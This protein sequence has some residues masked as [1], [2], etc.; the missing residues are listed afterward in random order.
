MRLILRVLESP[1]QNPCLPGDICRDEDGNWFVSQAH[2]KFEN[3]QDEPKT[4]SEPDDW[5]YT[6]DDSVPY[7]WVDVTDGTN[8]GLTEMDG[9]LNISLPFDFPFYWNHYSNLYIVTPGYLT[10]YEQPVVGQSEIPN[11]NLPNGIIAPFWAP[12]MP[13]M[14]TGWIRYMTGGTEPNRYLVV[15][16]YE[17]QDSHGNRFTFEVILY[18]NGNILFQYQQIGE[19]YWCASTGIES[20]TAYYG[21]AYP[22]WCDNYPAEG[23]AV[24]FTRPGPVARF[25]VDELYL[26]KFAQPGSDVYYYF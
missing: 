24:L 14:N 6:W 21:L 12:L 3:S 17:M 1:T 10:L 25:Y 9:Q 7:A 23:T 22:V 26:G 19:E 2:Q 13:E 15:E 8:T 20:E 11:D 18:E 16:W 5:G 4:R